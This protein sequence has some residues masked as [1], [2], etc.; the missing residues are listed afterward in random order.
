LKGLFVPRRKGHGA[1]DPR[2]AARRH[3]AE[4]C[5]P[6]V[7]VDLLFGPVFYRGLMRQEAVPPAFV[8]QLFEH[9]LAGLGSGRAG[10]ARRV[11]R[12]RGCGVAERLAEA[13][14]DSTSSP[15]DAY[16][17]ASVTSRTITAV[18]ERLIAAATV[19]GSREATKRPSD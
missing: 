3:R 5:L 11:G 4:R 6:Q 8:R 15:L 1:D 16:L 10:A 14:S 2:V 17:S 18:G 13:G 7:A 9:A 12:L 19:A